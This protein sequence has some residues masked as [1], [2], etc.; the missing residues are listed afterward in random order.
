MDNLR[1]DATWVDYDKPGRPPLLFIGGGKDQIVPA[2]VNQENSQRY[3][4]SGAHTDYV[5]LKDRDHYTIGAPGWEEVVTA[6]RMWAVDH[7]QAI[8]H[9][10]ERQEPH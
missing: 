7:A 10:V 9:A 4:R 1:L 2:D 5:E 6:A 8:E 3:R